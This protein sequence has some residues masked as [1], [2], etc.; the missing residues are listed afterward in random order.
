[1]KVGVSLL[2]ASLD[3][4]VITRYEL[5]QQKQNVYYAFYKEA[6]NTLLARVRPVKP[7]FQEIEP[8]YL[9][10]DNEAANFS[11]V[12]YEFSGDPRVIPNPL[13]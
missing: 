12:I 7:E 4:E 6:I 9:L 2:S 3:A 10:H 11:G 8:W 13:I 5:V 1:M